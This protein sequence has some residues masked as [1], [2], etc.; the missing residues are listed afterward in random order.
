[1][2]NPNSYP[3]TQNGQNFNPMDGMN[4]FHNMYEQAGNQQ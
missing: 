1:M 2:N 4:S 3:Q